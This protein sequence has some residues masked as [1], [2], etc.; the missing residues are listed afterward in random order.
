MGDYSEPRATTVATSEPPKDQSQC[1]RRIDAHLRMQCSSC[2]AFWSML[3]SSSRFPTACPGTLTRASV[4]T[5]RATHP[6]PLANAPTARMMRRRFRTY[7]Y[8][9]GRASTSLVH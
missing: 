5:H 1:H 2:I 3:L 9:L 7:S 6:T 8:V 4:Q